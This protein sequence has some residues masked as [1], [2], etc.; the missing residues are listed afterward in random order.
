MAKDSKKIGIHPE[1]LVQCIK[2]MRTLRFECAFPMRKVADFLKIDADLYEEYELG[3]TPIP[4]D[5]LQKLADLYDVELIDFL[6]NKDVTKES[7]I[8]EAYRT[9]EMLGQLDMRTL[10]AMTNF[11]RLV[12]QYQKM[13]SISIKEELTKSIAELNE[14]HSHDHSISVEPSQQ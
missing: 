14:L 2:N 10:Y 6:E 9:A 3:K 8:L 1:G 7:H 12:R 13:D 11:F 4:F 5:V